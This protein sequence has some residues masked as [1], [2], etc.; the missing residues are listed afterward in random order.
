[1]FGLDDCI[2]AIDWNPYTLPVDYNRENYT[3]ACPSNYH[4]WTWGGSGKIPEGCP[5]DC[6][7]MVAHYERCPTCGHERFLI[8]ESPQK[9]S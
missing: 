8:V 9:E 4:T 6:G 7:Q 1:M 3:S 5:C 2:S